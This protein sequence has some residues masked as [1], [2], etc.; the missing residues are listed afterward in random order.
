MRSAGFLLGVLALLLAGAAGRLTYLELARGPSLRAKAEKQHTATMRIPAQR[1]DI[2]DTKG[3]VLAGTRWRSS[4]FVDAALV[5]DPR[6]AAY[7]VAPVLRLNPSDLESL[8]VT[9]REDRFV[10]IKRRLDEA[11][12]REFETIRR[13]R[14]LDAFVVQQEPERVYP[15]DRTACHV[16]GFV[17][18]DQIGLAGIEQACQAHLTGEDGARRSTVDSQRRRLHSTSESYRAPRDGHSV[19]L[20]IDV[21]LQQ[22]VEYHLRNAVEQFK[23]KWGAAVLIDPNSGEVLAMANY[24]DFDP[25]EPF[26]AG[27]TEK[28]REECQERIRNR[29]LSDSYEPGSIFKPFI[30]GPALEDG[31]CRLDE[32]VAIN[33]PTRSFGGRI[34]HD[35]HAYGTLA[36]WEVI[37]KSSNI[38]M[39][40]LGGRLGNER[41]YRYLRGWGF[42]DPTGIGLPGEHDGI[43][44]DFSRWGPFSTQS[45][46]IG[47]EMSITPIQVAAAFSVFC[48]DGVLYRPRIVRGVVAADGRT[49]ADFSQ[50]VA[51][52]RVLSP[53]TARAIRVR[54][55][56]QTVVSGTG[57][58]AALT[59]WQ[60]FGK[61]GTA[62][63]ARSNGKGYLPGA[64]V[65]SFVGGA[66]LRQPRVA[67]IV[68]LY[69]TMGREY[70]GGT[71]AAP[72]AGAILADALQYMQVPPEP[73]LK[74]TD[75]L[76]TGD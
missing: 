33:G 23:A 26:P 16:L 9:R 34:I 42:G 60:V 24:P 44:R 74:G 32:M 17:G 21:H 1:G 54:G 3:R 7:S 59:D 37:S 48:N 35:T 49:V 19:I 15:N 25:R 11:E 4:V 47:Q 28:Q 5:D 72:A 6:F 30:V 64:Y 53:E 39:G 14:R 55:L 67:T 20:T 66:P 58:K 18:T 10:W 71:V 13:A 36:M 40:L 2:L 31:L 65:G 12:L 76:V 38:G 75:G 69:H 29:A 46:P 22:R 56:A 27:A 8:L 63:I 43:V 61:T 50:P 68:S 41:L 73:V 70:Y 52:R 62:Q 57:K 51:V 45:I